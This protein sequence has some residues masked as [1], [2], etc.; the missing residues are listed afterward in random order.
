MATGA[1]AARLKA[2]PPVRHIG[3]EWIHMTLQAQKP[4]LAPN[5]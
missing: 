1:I 3:R 2:Q 5:Q 4:G